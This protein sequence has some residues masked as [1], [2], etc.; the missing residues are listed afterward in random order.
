[1]LSVSPRPA[2]AAVYAT[3]HRVY[4]SLYPAL[5]PFFGML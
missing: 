5:K 3:G 1:V 2:E 4:Q